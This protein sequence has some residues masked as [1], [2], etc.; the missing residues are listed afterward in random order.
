MA[1]QGLWGDGLVQGYVR[2][3][4]ER[5]LLQLDSDEITPGF[6]GAPVWDVEAGCVIGMVTAVLSPDRYGRLGEVALATPAES[7]RQVCPEPGV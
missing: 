7:L 1:V 4:N 6:S 2:A 3:E 5:R